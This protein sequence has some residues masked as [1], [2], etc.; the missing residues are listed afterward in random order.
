MKGLENLSPLIRRFTETGPVGCSVMVAQD[1]KILFEDYA[2]VRD[3]ESKAPVDKDT[4]FRVY[5]MSK[6]ITVT[7]ALQLYEKGLYLLNDPISDYLPEWKDHRVVEMDP[8]GDWRPK[9]AEKPLLVKDFFS[10]A[11]G[12]PYGGPDSITAREVDR[13]MP[14][15]DCPVREASK[16]L[17][18]V[19]LAFEPGTHW[20][21]GLSHD[22]LGAFIEVL[23]GKSFGEYLEENI[24][25]PLGMKE[26]GFR[27]RPGQAE[28][29]AG[30]YVLQDGTRVRE[31]TDE[32]DVFQP[33]A[34]YE[35]GGGGLLSTLGDYT[36]FAQAL[37]C[38][39]TLDGVRILGSQTIDLMRM[40]HLSDQQKRDF[41][42]PFLAGY[43]YGLGVRTMVNPQAGG[44]NGSLGEFGWCGKL[45]TWVMIDP[46]KRLTAVYMQQL[47]PNLEAIHQAR[48][49]AVIY[50]A[51]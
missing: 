44:C 45:G 48:M 10:M 29:L 32:D 41:N 24:F 14:G 50:G 47:T 25:A 7:A 8:N 33:Q 17:S 12:L 13:V 51:L 31:K 6:V 22:V 9:K 21:Y 1:G 46:S 3:L 2:G 42:W 28:R 20:H 5:S 40:D 43:S 39:G 19:P 15:A 36:R 30:R 26:T 38:G 34:K 16:I 27:L 4:V 23:S 18:Q 11:T 37:A 35:S 49:R